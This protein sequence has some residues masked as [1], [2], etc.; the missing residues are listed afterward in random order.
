VSKSLHVFK[1]MA[2]SVA[3]LNA[4]PFLAELKAMP[5]AAKRSEKA[6]AFADAA[7]ENAQSFYAKGEIDKRRRPTGRHEQCAQ[8]MCRLTGSGPKAIIVQKGGTESGTP[9]T[10]HAGAR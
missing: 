8:R 7:F 10:V 6:L 3:L 9:T 4:Q 2:L 1:A 5:N